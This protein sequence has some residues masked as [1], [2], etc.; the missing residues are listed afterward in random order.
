MIVC[1]LRSGKLRREQSHGL[2]KWS[3]SSFFLGARTT[4]TSAITIGEDKMVNGGWSSESLTKNSVVCMNR[5]CSFCHKERGY[6]GLKH[7]LDVKMLGV[8][9]V[10]ESA[11]NYG[12]EWEVEVIR[13]EAMRRVNCVEDVGDEIITSVSAVLTLKG[14][15]QAH[16]KT[17]SLGSRRRGCNNEEKYRSRCSS[18]GHSVYVFV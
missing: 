12:L 15:L 2:G 1:N 10:K 7:R 18:S 6:T 8:V 5:G 14:C 4:V 11:E 3:C 17:H 9:W 13:V 16:R